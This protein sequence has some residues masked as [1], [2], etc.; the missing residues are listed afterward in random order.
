MASNLSASLGETL[1]KTPGLSSTF[2]GPGAS[3]PVIRGQGG[4]R[5]RILDNGIGSIDASSASPDH[6]TS[7]EPAIATRIEIIRGT[8]LLRYGSSASGGVI[9]VIDGRIPDTVPKKAITGAVRVGAS[10]VDDGYE[11][12][13]GADVKLGDLS[14][15]SLVGH[16]DAN[17]RNTEDYNIPG[18][19]ESE[20]LR[21]FEDEAGEEREEAQDILEN[22]AAESRA[23][24]AGLSWIGQE[25][26]VG[27]AVRNLDSNYGI[28][29]GEADQDEG[30]AGSEEEGGVTIDLKQTRI[31]ALARFNLTVYLKP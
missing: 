3:R 23:F 10:S 16:V 18:F 11:G 17:Y 30:E 27:I 15:G 8:G 5:I 7:V 26:I 25:T 2:F 9:N 12:S 1:K 4:D 24:S 21:A 14:G 20:I 31:D 29:G 6:A 13:I 19:A 22:S 28:P